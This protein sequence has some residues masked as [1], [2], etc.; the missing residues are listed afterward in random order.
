MHIYNVRYWSRAITLIA[1]CTA[2]A[3]CGF[4]LK[5]ASNLPFSTIYTNIA[6]NSEFGASVR[7]YIKAGSPNV[8]F[9]EDPTSADVHLIQLKLSETRRE[10]SLDASGDVEEYELNLNFEFQLT[11]KDG[12]IIL[13]PTS[14]TASRDIPYDPDDSQAK[15]G[16]ITM[17]FTDMRQSLVARIVRILSS[18]AVTEAI[19]E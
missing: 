4:R 15:E 11:D 3:A 13:P 18:P 16:E 8:N 1:L 5:G 17:T 9:T 12:E 14:L 10:L 6:E 2:L 7:R 19:N